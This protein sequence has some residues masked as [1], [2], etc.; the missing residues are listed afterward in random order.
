MSRE[1][2]ESPLK[3]SGAFD[4]EAEGSPGE[5]RGNATR[6]L[7]LV[8]AL[9]ERCLEVVSRTDSVDLPHDRSPSAG[10]SRWRSLSPPGRRRLAQLPF[11]IVDIHFMDHGWWERASAVVVR[12]AE[13]TQRHAVRDATLGALTQEAMLLAWHAVQLDRVAATWKIGMSRGV[14]GV[15]WQLSAQDV[16]R[17]AARFPGEAEPRWSN[18]VD[19]WHHMLVT[20]EEGNH[21]TIQDA[22]REAMLRLSGEM[23]MAAEG[24]Q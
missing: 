22:R 4:A 5:P 20:A 16:L 10:T 19:L 2:K 24:G 6:F 18:A 7:D 8:R 1:L 3:R 11:L 21:D 12:A 14:A 9:N 13:L 17:V 15:I 23:V